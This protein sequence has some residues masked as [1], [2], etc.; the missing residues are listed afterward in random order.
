MR[1]GARVHR[2]RGNA[3]GGAVCAMPTDLHKCRAMMLGCMPNAVGKASQSLGTRAK[4]GRGLAHSPY[5]PPRSIRAC[6]P[7]R[8]LPPLDRESEPNAP[9]PVTEA[10]AWQWVR[11]GTSGWR[12]VIGGYSTRPY[13]TPKQRSIARRASTTTRS[14]SQAD[15]AMPC[16]DASPDEGHSTR[17]WLLGCKRQYAHDCADCSQMPQGRAACHLTTVLRYGL[18]PRRGA[19]LVARLPWLSRQYPMWGYVRSDG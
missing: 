17:C 9:P 14:G 16:S 11:G 5:S 15:N 19:I 3:T 1:R 6:L 10:E 2:W 18:L 12:V 13:I 7:S 8:T 4:R